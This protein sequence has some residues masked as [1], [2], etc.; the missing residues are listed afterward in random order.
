[1]AVAGTGRDRRSLPRFQLVDA[2]PDPEDVGAFSGID[3]SKLMGMFL[4]IA[5]GEPGLMGHPG[6]S[7]G[8]R[9]GK[10]LLPQQRGLRTAPQ[11]RSAHGNL[12]RAGRGGN[13]R[14]G[15]AGGKSS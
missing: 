2:S 5:G 8:R 11:G 7:L 9:L 6:H 15:S 14:D 4:G 12:Y 1:M 13:R 3:K 10:Y